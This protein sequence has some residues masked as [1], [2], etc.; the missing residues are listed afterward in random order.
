MSSAFPTIFRFFYF[1]RSFRCAFVF[2]VAAFTGVS[3]LAHGVHDDAVPEILMGVT[4]QV[5]Q[6]RLQILGVEV[7]AVVRL[8]KRIPGL[9]GDTLQDLVIHVPGPVDSSHGLC[10]RAVVEG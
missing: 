2:P 10:S 7:V 5:E 3:L 1:R 9:P 8:L 6:H 4:G